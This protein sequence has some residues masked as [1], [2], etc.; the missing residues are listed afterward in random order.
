MLSSILANKGILIGI[1]FCLVILG[2]ISYFAYH[3]YVSPLFQSESYIENSEFHKAKGGEIKDV[4][5]IFFY[6]DWCPH[7][8]KGL[9]VWKEFKEKFNTKHPDKIINKYRVH[10]SEVDCDKDEESANKFDITG[11]PTIKLVKSETEIIEL[12][13]RL[14]IDSLFEFLNTTLN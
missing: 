12:D 7:S 1:F 3:K 13:A 2:I 6:T 10:M 9:K 11:Y 14:E 5:L 4:N 8:Q